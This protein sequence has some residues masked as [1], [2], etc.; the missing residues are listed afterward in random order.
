MFHIVLLILGGLWSKTFYAVGLSQYNQYPT[1]I[2][3]HESIH[4]VQEFWLIQ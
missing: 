3:A 2:I 4:I 1:S